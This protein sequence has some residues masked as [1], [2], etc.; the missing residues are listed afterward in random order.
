MTSIS[1]SVD[2]EQV[3]LPARLARNLFGFTAPVGQRNYAYFGFSLML[4]KYVVEAIML[5]R[6]QAS[7]IPR[8]IL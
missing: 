2:H 4:V 1:P 3:W 6:E 7:F 5:G 8:S